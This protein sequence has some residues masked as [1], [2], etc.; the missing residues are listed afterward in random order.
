MLWSILLQYYSLY[1]GLLYYSRMDNTMDYYTQYYGLLMYYTIGDYTMAYIYYTMV[2]TQFYGLLYYGSILYY[3]RMDNT[4][5][6]YAQ[7]YTMDVYAMAY[8]ITM[9]WSI[10]WRISTILWSILSITIA[11]RQQNC[12]GF[13]SGA[14][15]DISYISG[16]NWNGIL[17]Y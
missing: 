2:Y 7:Y 5:D 4:M 15:S 6:Y 11:Q 1:Y 17:L 13:S 16:A 8:T 12:E 14:S 10:L 9:L 3:S